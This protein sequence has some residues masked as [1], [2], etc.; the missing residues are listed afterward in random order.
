MV[1]T[2]HG[3]KVGFC[4]Q[5]F[6]SSPWKCAQCILGFVLKISYK[7]IMFRS[8]QEILRNSCAD[9]VEHLPKH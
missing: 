8:T 9:D 4:S 5:F 6:F 2:E 3:R 1:K 7:L